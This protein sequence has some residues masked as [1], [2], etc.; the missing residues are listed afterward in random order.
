MKKNDL[1]LLFWNN[2]KNL[3][4][5][6][7]SKIQNIFKKLYFKNNNYFHGIFKY[8]KKIKNSSNIHDNGIIEFS[9]DTVSGSKVPKK[10]LEDNDEYFDTN[11]KQE[12]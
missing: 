8:L 7:F 3:F 12:Q 1:I 10:L 11:N 5:K 6:N 2:F 4:V 9:A